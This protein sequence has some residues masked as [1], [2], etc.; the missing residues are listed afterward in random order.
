MNPTPAQQRRPDI[1]VIGMAAD[2][3]GAPGLDAFWTTIR[4]GR[5]NITHGTPRVQEDPATGRRR[6]HARGLIE[7]VRRFDAEFFGIPRREAEV[8]DP[9]H[10]HLLE[11]SWNAMEDAGYDPYRLREDVAVYTSVGPNTYYQGRDFEARSAAERM[12]AQL[13]N[14]PDTLP[15]RISY[16]LGLTG[17]SVNVQ[18]ACSSA[19]V[20]VHLACEALR[21]GRA[22]MA[23]VGAVSIGTAETLAYEHQE[24]FILSGD[25]STRAY[26]KGASGYVEGDGGGVL[27]LRRLDDALARRD[28]VRAVIKG[29]AVN[30]DGR[31]KAGFSAPG[32]EGQARVVRAAIEDAGVPAESIGMIEGHGTGTLVGDPIEV[33]ALTRAH[34]TYTQGT[35]YAALGSVKPNIGHLCFA[36]GIAGLLKAVLC[37]EHGEIPPMAVLEEPNPEIDFAG[38]PFYLNREVRPWP[39]EGP[40][41]AGVS[42]FGMGG[43]NA[44]F[45]LEQAPQSAPRAAEEAPRALPVMLSGATDQAL[46]QVKRLLRDHL[47]TRPETDL[48]D[49]AYTLATGRRPLAHRWAVAVRSTAELLAALDGAPAADGADGPA[50]VLARAWAAGESADLAGAFPEDSRRIPLP[51]YPWQGEP[52]WIEA[53]PQDDD[54]SEGVLLEAQEQ[55]PVA[56]WLYRPA[57]RRTALPRPY[58]PGDLPAPAGVT[59]LLG[60]EDGSPGAALADAL[61]AELGATG[62]TVLRVAAGD[63]YAVRSGHRFEVRPGA[64]EDLDRLVARAVEL[65]GSVSEVVHLWSWGEPADQDSGIARGTLGV[66]HLVQALA[67]RRQQSDLWIV[68]E[69][70][71]SARSL[72]GPAAGAPDDSCRTL[73]AE[74]AGLLGLAK[75]IPQEHPE[76]R[77]RAVDFALGTPAAEAVPRLL[78]E[79]AAPEE[80][81]EVVIRGGDRLVP[82]VEAVPAAAAAGPRI[83]PGGV[84]LVTGGLG[85][86]GLLIAG[87]FARTAPVK[88]ALVSRTARNDAPEAEALRALGAE[89]AVLAADVADE[90]AMRA[91]V[92]EVRTRW[93]GI[94]G[95]VHSA[96]IEESRNFSFLAET[97]TDR[98]RAALRPKVPGIAVLDRVT[99]AE[100]PEFV[101]VCSSLDTVLGGIAFGIYST[102]NRYLDTYAHRR[103]AEGA[104]WTSVDW[105]SWR[106]STEDGGAARI[107]AAAARTAIRPDQAG[108]IVDAVL[109]ADQAQCVVSTVP[110][111]E[112]IERIR[113]SF[114]RRR[115]AAAEAGTGEELTRA[116]VGETVRTVIAEVTDTAGPREED[117]L[118]DVGCDSLALLEAVVRLESALQLKLP[119]ADLWGCTTLADLADVCWRLAGSRTS[120]DAEAAAEAMR[121]LAG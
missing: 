64:A 17:E 101:L 89:V 6:V 34:R 73:R 77:C 90:D 72:G 39:G 103:R 111:P 16:K 85:R 28:T 52:L 70:A 112:R 61:A 98:A 97:D 22:D 36:S 35:G 102:A 26:D 63:A 14:E 76:L 96:G 50:A 66:L 84:Y 68:T 82:D 86:I 42:C 67:A 95:V 109:A 59:L 53:A 29:S 47:L 33:R 100:E 105:D 107:G 38:T 1:A 9:Q 48:R 118:L 88:L 4:E 45:V 31:V 79:L 119:M 37:L 8:L 20:A 49:L 87:H 93:G 71:Q 54:A 46:R 23:L 91:V 104:P 81:A 65:D 40:R 30:N 55:A 12:L 24:G 115:R 56:D 13:S 75:V 10:R 57:W 110:L 108:E 121:Y 114:D 41:R 2:L 3:P 44:H 5:E 19:A 69:N 94:D 60:G 80:D 15:T 25:G 58:H 32:V 27:V 51:G 92:T 99:R 78:A 21:A 62:R 120:P 74:A 11:L 7:D 113:R 18:S 106:F 117:S 43:T 116:S 83:K